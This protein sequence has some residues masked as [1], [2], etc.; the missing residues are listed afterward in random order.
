M[1]LLLEN[2]R[3]RLRGRARDALVAAAIVAGVLAIVLAPTAD[4]RRHQPACQG[5]TSYVRSAPASEIRAAVVC[6]LNDARV[7]HGLPRLHGSGALGR[8]AQHWTD[9]M[10]SGGSLSHGSN[11]GARVSAAGFRWSNV[12]EIVGAGYGTPRQIVQAWM[13][14]PTHCQ[15]ILDPTFAD[16]GTGVARHAVAGYANRGGTW[17]ADFALASGRRAPSGNWGPANGCPY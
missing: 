11:V 16:V 9:V 12:G 17:T 8:S 7:N 5:A 14:S 15:V 4:A 2:H 10:V 1:V 13:Q 3:A 6:L